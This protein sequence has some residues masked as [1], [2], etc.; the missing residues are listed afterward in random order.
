MM[1]R[2]NKADA[3]MMYR[4]NKADAA[5]AARAAEGA[6][7]SWLAAKAFS[8]GLPVHSVIRIQETK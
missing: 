7:A 4:M 8:G 2:M 1:Y 5:F 3:I 6:R